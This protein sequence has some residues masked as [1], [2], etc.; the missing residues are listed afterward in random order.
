M[1]AQ[2]RAA[3]PR[4]LSDVGVA[5]LLVA[6]QQA[7]EHLI[8]G[9]LPHA[10][11]HLVLAALPLVHPHL[12]PRAHACSPMP[13][14]PN[15]C[16]PSALPVLFVPEHG[17]PGTCRAIFGLPACRKPTWRMLILHAAARHAKGG[18]TGTSEAWRHSLGG[19]SARLEQVLVV[20]VAHGTHA[21]RLRRR[22]PR[23]W[24]DVQRQ[25]ALRRCAHLAASPHA[26]AWHA[27]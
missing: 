3:A 7:R 11:V 22:L 18:R 21:D 6:E 26:H 20:G 17:D 19:K 12:R 8:H 13:T 5:G 1:Q 4:E 27:G 14:P 2:A 24:V 23:A 15:P 16:E 10:A 9:A 25:Q